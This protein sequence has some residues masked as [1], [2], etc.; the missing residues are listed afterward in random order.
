[1]KKKVLSIA[2][3][4]IF[5]ATISCDK[6]TSNSGKRPVFTSMSLPAKTEQV[7]N[8]PHWSSPPEMFIDV[9]KNYIADIKTELGDIQIQLFVDKAPITVNNFVFLSREKFYDNTSF[10]RVIK[11]F[12]AQA[13]KPAGEAAEGPGYYIPD[14]K[15]PDLFFDEPGYVAMVSH[16]QPNLN[17]SQFFISTYRMAPYFDGMVT[18]FG[19]VV[20]G[21][22]IL[23]ALKLRNPDYDSFEGTRIS[24]IEISEV[25]ESLLPSP[26]PRQIK[27]PVLVE[28]R[29]LAKLPVEEREYIYNTKP[30]MVIKKSQSYTADI[31]TNIGTIVVQLRPDIAPESVNNFYIL[32]KLGYWDN[33]PINNVVRSRCVITGIPMEQPNSDVGY[34]LPPEFNAEF[35]IARG[36][37]G[38]YIHARQD[39]QRSSS[40]SIL[41]FMKT[42]DPRGNYGTVFGQ[43]SEKSMELVD[44]L[45]TNDKIIRIEI[46]EK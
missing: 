41:Y 31:I 23:Y 25:P 10:Y 34:Y 35:L 28:G 32:A 24:T 42:N 38:Y 7:L 6:N 4:F 22:D 16:G 14:E 40:G 37:L 9:T 18:I 13:G 15:S 8:Y 2:L 19:K 11:D 27:A 33:F 29:P 44:K 39:N 20:K 45:T 30:D 46:I 12:I 5:L 36:K 3:W 43:I 21:M 1:M 17:G 26:K